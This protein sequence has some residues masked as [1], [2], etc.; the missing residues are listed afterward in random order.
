MSAGMIIRPAVFGRM[1]WEWAAPSEHW[2]IRVLSTAMPVTPHSSQ[3]RHVLGGHWHVTLLMASAP[4][5]AL[6]HEAY[7]RQLMVRLAST[8]IFSRHSALLC[9]GCAPVQTP[10]N[11]S[12]IWQAGEAQSASEL[13]PLTQEWS[14][15]RIH[16][17]LS[18]FMEQRF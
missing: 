7:I 11:G 15:A 3:S 17:N 5:L 8:S 10:E 14:S 12:H 6:L 2:V 9:S 16:A 18:L 1:Q 13:H 4:N